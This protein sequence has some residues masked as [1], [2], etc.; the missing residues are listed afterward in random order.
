VTCSRCRH[1][2][3][4]ATIHYACYSHAHVLGWLQVAGV[5]SEQGKTW[6]IVCRTR[7]FRWKFFTAQYICNAH[8]YAAAHFAVCPLQAGIHSGLMV[9]CLTAVWEDPSSNLTA[10]SC[11]YH[12]SHCDIYSLG[13]G[14][15]TLTAVPR[16]TQPSTFRGMVKWVS[17]LGLS[18][19]KNGDGGCGW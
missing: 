6:L 13:H 16:L 3:G 11:V 4:I 19:N 10:G 17:A 7:F 15:H 12:D 2:Y 9:T 18:N 5:D 8:A 1:S 14:L